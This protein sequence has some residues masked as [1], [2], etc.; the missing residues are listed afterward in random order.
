MKTCLVTGASRGI[1]AAIAAKF[2]NEGYS[3][4]VNYAHSHDQAEQLVAA[5]R[6]SGC[7]AHLFRADLADV[8]Q[9]RAMFDWVGKYFKHLDVLVNNAGIALVE[10]LQDV[11]ER[12]F[13]NV[14]SV[15]AKAA[16]FCTQA[17]LPLLVKSGEAAVVNVSSVW[18]CKGASCES[19]YSMS[20]HA[21]VGLTRSL[22][23][24][25]APTVRV[26]CVCPPIVQT[27]MTAHLSE[28]DKL[29]FC[30]QHGTR[31]LTAQEVANDVFRLAVC[32]TTG[33]IF[34]EK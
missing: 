33:E 34:S 14:F 23:Q 21:L 11:T 25:L 1:G 4:I 13:D 7:D 19:V 2:A 17:A 22:A 29:L 32:G 30:T 16:F 24:E 27:D 28:Q 31:V 9:I 18:G 12:D 8:A 5:L 26:N 6:Q 15:N 20:K 10:Q 3:V